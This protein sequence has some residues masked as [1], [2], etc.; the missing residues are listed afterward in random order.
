ML[1][2]ARNY[3]KKKGAIMKMKLSLLAAT[4]ILTIGMTGCWSE[5]APTTQEALTVAKALDGYL[6]G[7]NVC[8]DTDGNESTCEY[9]TETNSTTGEYKIPS[10][11]NV[12]TNK[13]I[14]SGGID[15][16]T[17][18]PFIGVLKSTANLKVATPLTTLLADGMTAA[19][20]AQLTGLSIAN[21]T[22]DYRD[23]TFDTTDALVNTAALKVQTILSQITALFSAA[24]TTKSPAEITKAAVDAINTTLGTSTT[25][26]LSN[27]NLTTVVTAVITAIPTTNPITASTV[28]NA[29][30]ASIDRK[31]VV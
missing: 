28:A 12:V 26:T 9:T 15:Q 27:L 4:A 30:T 23:G 17:N 3:R 29:I 2:N 16:D 24:G 22:T 18:A 13:V 20:I 21:I 6:L 25:T 14:I 19:E 5:N 1:Y 7:A 31:S 10:P 11:Y 8:V